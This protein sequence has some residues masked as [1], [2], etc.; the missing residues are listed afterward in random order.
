M[1]DASLNQMAA[2]VNILQIIGNKTERSASV[3][4]NLSSVNSE[5][6]EM[7]R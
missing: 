5:E 4:E 6:L 1:N 7:L 2:R 3:F